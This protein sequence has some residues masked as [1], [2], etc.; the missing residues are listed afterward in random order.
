[1]FGSMSEDTPLL[2]DKHV[3]KILDPILPLAKFSAV[4]FIYHNR[5][6]VLAALSPGLASDS[7][8]S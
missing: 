1:M 5:Y 3:Q 6:H 7:K 2:Q 4:P 8:C